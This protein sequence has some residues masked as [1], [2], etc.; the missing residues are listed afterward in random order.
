MS[1]DKQ[2]KPTAEATIGR[3]SFI[4]TAALAGLV[5]VVGFVV[6]VVALYVLRIYARV[7]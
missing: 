1:Q 5:G 6:V 2:Q 3:R 4:N 7:A